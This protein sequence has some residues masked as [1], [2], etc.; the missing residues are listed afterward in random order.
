MGT[1]VI[2]RDIIGPE[3]ADQPT[4]SRDIQGSLTP[5]TFL[6]SPFRRSTT[7]ASVTTSAPTV[8]PSGSTNNLPSLQITTSIQWPRTL[9]ASPRVSSP[10][11][12]VHPFIASHTMPPPLMHDC[13]RKTHYARVPRSKSWRKTALTKRAHRSTISLCPRWSYCCPY[14]TIFITLDNERPLTHPRR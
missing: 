3:P 5:T 14:S 1:R 7:L 11:P 10:P 6:L 8:I 9:P 2:T 12:I 13:Y 4:V